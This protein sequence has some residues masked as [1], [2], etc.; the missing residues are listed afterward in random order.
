MAVVFHP[1]LPLFAYPVWIADLSMP[2]LRRQP[3][4]S[5]R[6]WTLVELLVVIAVIGIVTALTL[7][8]VQ[9]VRETARQTRCK[10]HLRQIGLALHGYHH[11]HATLPMGCFEWRHYFAPPNRRNFAWSAAILPNLERGNVY[12]AIDYT[13]PFDHPNNASAGATVLPV[14]MCPSV[15]PDPT[16]RLGETHYGGLFGETLVNSTKDDGVL[17]YDRFIRFRDCFDG[18][19]QTI[20]V[21]EDV[22]GPHGQWINGSNVF[23]Q[24]HGINDDRA[25][26]FDNEI[27]SLHPAGAPV[28]LLD[29]SV[30]F[31]NE[32]IDRRV[33]GSLITRSNREIISG[34]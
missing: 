34:F 20:V 22:V 25:W 31:L 9:Q 32:S 30:H 12:E 27:R 6:A 5:R 29:G 15:E 26:K 16:A 19:S 14:Y 8:A 7:P 11:M 2:C 3:P 10:N 23:V 17:V 13:V 4:T 33:L 28:T 21:S 24:S 18:L 1:A